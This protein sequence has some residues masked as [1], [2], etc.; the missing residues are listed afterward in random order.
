MLS[1][2]RI[3]NQVFSIFPDCGNALTAHGTDFFNVAHPV[4]LY[5]HHIDVL[6]ADA[7]FLQKLA[8]RIGIAGLDKRG[9][10]SAF[11]GLGNEILGKI[12]AGKRSKPEILFNFLPASE[13]CRS[14]IIE[15][16][17]LLPAEN[18]V[19]AAVFQQLNRFLN[20]SFLHRRSSSLRFGPSFATVATKSFMVAANFAPSA[21]ETHSTRVRSRSIP[22]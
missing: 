2:Q 8:K 7:V 11:P 18:P 3:N 22:K 15:E 20:Q 6:P 5:A 10:F 19:N 17:A 12:R 13:N 16:L 14:Q 9:D 1:V 21:A 4:A